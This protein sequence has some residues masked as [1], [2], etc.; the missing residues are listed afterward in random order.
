MSR[1]PSLSLRIVLAVRLFNFFNL[2][3]AFRSLSALKK[4][5]ESEFL[6]RT[7]HLEILKLEKND[8]ESSGAPTQKRFASLS[9]SASFLRSV[10]IES[11]KIGFG[12]VEKREKN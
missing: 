2:F 4:S 11:V 5:F 6:L 12:R 10:P 1:G 7:E 9:C 8:E 3:C